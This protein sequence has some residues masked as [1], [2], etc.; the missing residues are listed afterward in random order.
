M[1]TSSLLVTQAAMAAVAGWV[2]YQAAATRFTDPGITPPAIEAPASP[3][4]GAGAGSP[5]DAASAGT[6]TPD[7]GTAVS[8]PAFVAA[9]A[10][11]P[12]GTAAP[13]VS[14]RQAVER[15]A[16]S[17]VTVYSARR[18]QRGFTR[19]GD[20]GGQGLGS[21]VVI[22]A[23]G[24]IVTNNHVVEGASQ[25]AIAMADGTIRQARLVGTDPE[26]DLAV[27]RVDAA[28][29]KP[30]ELGDTRRLAVGDVVLAVGNPLGVGQTVTQ[31]IVSATGRKRLGINPIE[32]FVQ[33]DAAINPGNS[34][35][36]LIDT[37]GR[38]VGINTA[39]LSR[40]GGSEGIGFAIPVELAKQVAMTLATN[41]RVARGWFG[42]AAEDAAARLP[43]PGAQGA[44]IRS[45]QGGGPAARAGIRAG[46]VL[47]QLGELKI[48]SAD[49]LVS[50]ALELEPGR[51]VDA[52]VLR[53]G[54][55]VTVPIQLG[56][57]PPI[58]RGAG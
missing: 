58:R 1:K 31:G 54:K 7:A 4:A 16:P 51:E 30:I 47:V 35:G 53:D 44:L 57:R 34:G 20:P 49:D 15:A 33:T 3:G 5:G 22:D 38:L 26:T 10:N 43:G 42:V 6:G 2:G 25:L 40:G 45:V 24:L 29:L 48:A 32:N 55:R 56:R 46:D 50:A 8:G 23:S 39:I 14:F 28:D 41:G 37:A 19:S 9:A 13:P 27:L 52:V 18:P 21:G 11:A 12:A 36:A 17:V